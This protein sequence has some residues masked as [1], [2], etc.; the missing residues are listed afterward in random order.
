MIFTATDVSSLS[1]SL[2]RWEWAEYI[3]EAFVILACA[4]ELVAD[5]GGGLAR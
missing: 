2:Y 3:S 1:Q 4:G 5:L